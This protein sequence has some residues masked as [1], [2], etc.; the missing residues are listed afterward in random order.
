MSSKPT[1]LIPAILCIALLPV[2][3]LAVETAEHDHTHGQ[4]SQTPASSSTVPEAAT[5][6]AAA[7]YADQMRRMTELHEKMK[8]TRI[9][10]ERQKLMAENMKLLQEGMA[11]MMAMQGLPGMDMGMM[12][13]DGMDMSSCMNMHKPMNQRMDMMEM[14]MQMMLDQQMA[15]ATRK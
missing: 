7:S 9:P 3:A 15:G 2:P 8:A 5:P 11:L 4:K 1:S 12:G 14:M 13:K 10:A 6:L